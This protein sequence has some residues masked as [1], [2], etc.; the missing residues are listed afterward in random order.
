MM[1]KEY[2]IS[3]VKCTL[4]MDHTLR[5]TMEIE[6]ILSRAGNIVMEDSELLLS[7]ILKCEKPVDYLEMK[8]SQ[9]T[10]IVTDYMLQKKSWRESLL[11][12]CLQSMLR[13]NGLNQKSEESQNDNSVT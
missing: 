7:L 10:E 2:V 11:E 5:E 13:P 1:G 6:Q 12:K 3:G 4:E 9:L 8:E